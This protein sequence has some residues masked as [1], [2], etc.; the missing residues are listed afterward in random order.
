MQLKTVTGPSDLRDRT[1]EELEDL[2][3][4]IRSRIIEAVNARGGHL[5]SNLGAVELTV[6]LHRV[7]RSPHDVILW[8][9]G[10][11]AY[12]HKMLTGRVADFDSLR[13]A[14]GLAGYPSQTESSHDWVENSHASTALS[15]AHGLATAF[16]ASDAR[17][18]VVA[19]VGDGALTG[20]MA[21]EGLNNIGHSGRNVIIV[22][23]DNGRSYA[24]TVSRLSE[25]LVSRLSESLV[26]LRSN[27]KLMRRSDRVEELAERIPWVG[28]MVQQGVK[29][30]KAAL[31]ELWDS[32][33][34][35][36]NLGIR[37]LGPFD[38][39]DIAGLEEAMHN[40]E[41]FEGP[42]LLHVLTQKGRGYGPA[43]QDTV[44]HMHDVGK[45][46][47][48]SY[49]GMFSETMVKLGGL[50]PEVVAITAAMPDS[51]GLLPFRE[52]FGERCIDVGIAE[53]HAVTSA[54]GMAMGGLRPFFA[55]YSTF[56]SRAFDQ[57]NLDCGLHRAPVVFCIDRAGITGDDGPSHHGVL[58]MVLLTKVPGMVVLAPSSLQ[59][60]ERMMFD[61]VEITDRPVAIRWPKT[62]APSVSP[63]E[64]GSGLQARRAREG[65]GRL[66]L[67]GVGKML[68]PCEQAADLL[69]AD[70]INANVWDPRA[71]SP[72]CDQ[73]LAAAQDCELVVT[74][75][76]GLRV[77]GAGTAF[78]EALLQRAAATGQAAPKVCK[79]GVPLEY[80]PHGKPDAILADLGLDA[81]GIAATVKQELL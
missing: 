58:D 66:C 41:Q 68:Q 4:Q 32:A 37:Y 51:T 13:V 65:D 3:D 19:V 16:E 34:F 69:A 2:C 73:M 40:A 42:V 50:H 60:L 44:K 22:L 55:V 78:Q 29:M 74:V 70:G 38:G 30:S 62:A 77:G 79:L 52:H 35:F 57:V 18:R 9:T 17:R 76:D 1:L 25:N 80:L 56:L 23:N 28:D 21:F 15:Y 26:R 67:I 20:G 5:G 27:P 24:P 54:V 49:T 47:S 6:A 72:L 10:H 39:H 59:E 11:Q 12:V 36:E 14:G 8:D 61:A 75:E 53:Q 7:F 46:K 45:V 64:V 43:E 48:D 71:V 63:N 81:A 31:L 33:G